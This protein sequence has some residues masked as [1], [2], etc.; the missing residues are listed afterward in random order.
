ML[1][2]TRL[3]RASPF[4]ASSRHAL[5]RMP[6]V[7]PTSD[8]VTLNRWLAREGEEVR[9]G[10]PILEIVVEDAYLAPVTLDVEAESHCVV[11]CHLVEAP[12][13]EVEVGAPVAVLTYGGG[14]R[15]RRVHR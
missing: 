2:V 12:S 1:A 13:K 4:T 9:A 15:T 3:A 5:L 6:R 14:R 7:S 8:T 10:D 11:E